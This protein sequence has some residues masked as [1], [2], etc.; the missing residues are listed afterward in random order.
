MR[1]LK[2]IK[3]VGDPEV[4]PEHAAEIIYHIWLII[5]LGSPRRCQKTLLERNLS[6]LH[7]LAC[8]YRDPTLDKPNKMDEII[9]YNLHNSH[10]PTKY[11]I[12]AVSVIGNTQLTSKVLTSSDEVGTR[13][14]CFL[15]EVEPPSPEIVA[16]ETGIL[17]RTRTFY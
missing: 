10:S 7:G 16:N 9:L 8:C 17:S 6:E 1:V 2:H 12:I 11:Q 5:A 14:V 4:D 15:R 3:L 13:T